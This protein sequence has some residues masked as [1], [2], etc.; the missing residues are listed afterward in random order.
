[1]SE[2]KNKPIIF[3]DGVCNLCHGFVQFVIQRDR[4]EAF[5]FASLQGETAARELP[6][7]FVEGA[8]PKTVVL[9]TP[10]GEVFQ[11]S[12]AVLKIVRE[13]SGLWPLL[14]IFRI[15]PRP[16]RDAVYDLVARYRYRLFGKKDACPL[17]SPE[18]K[19]RF[20]P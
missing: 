10:K 6:S 7:N 12:T 2:D 14:A 1:M 19:Q 9:K 20:L 8:S 5:Q 15:I 16:I 11:K 4:R 18:Q 17:P 13:F 3:F